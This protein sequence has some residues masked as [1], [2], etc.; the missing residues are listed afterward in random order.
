M[1]SMKIKRVYQNISFDTPSLALS[2]P[3]SSVAILGSVVCAYF[4]SAVNIQ[5]CFS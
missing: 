3:Q 5:A 2:S 1:D 4:I